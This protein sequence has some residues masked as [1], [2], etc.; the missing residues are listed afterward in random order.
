MTRRRRGAL[1][2]AG[3]AL[4]LG[5]PAAGQPP[6]DAPGPRPRE[7]REVGSH[8]GGAAGVGLSP[9]GKWVASG[10]GDQTIRVWA[11]ATGRE[12]RALPGASGFT[13]CVAFS[14][15]GKLLASAGYE[16]DRSRVAVYLYDAA[17]GAERGRL[18]GHPGGAR[19]LA[20][21]PDGKRLV[22]GGFD[23][24][25][26][27]WDLATNKELRC[28]KVRGC[29]FGLALS[30]DVRT[31]A[32]ADNGGT[33]L[34]ELDTGKELRKFGPPSAQALAVALSPD[35]RLLASGGRRSVTLYEVAT[36]KEVRTLEG[37]GE[38]LSSLFFSPDGRLLYSGS[39][40]HTV[41]V[42]E[43]FTGLEARK[44]EGHT[45]WVWNLALTSDGRSLASC[46]SDGRV[47]LWDVGGPPRPDRTVKLSPRELEGYWD[48]LA[49][50]AA[51]RA[52]Q[53]VHALAASSEQS[54]PFLKAR[55][56]AV[57]P[58]K[59]PSD[60]E[61]A[62]LV[63]ELDDNAFAVRQRAEAELAKAGRSAEAVLR[64]AAEKPASPEVRRRAERLL[65]AFAAGRPKPEEMR[66]V[67][68]VQALEYAGTAEAREALAAL[69]A[70]P[71][72][73]RLTREAKRAADRLAKKK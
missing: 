60:E 6:A 15:D 12:L 27:V 64:R 24:T 56:G 3:V 58:A 61:L 26:R 46:G 7:Y 22:S 38:Q 68:G 36:G 73:E 16:K 48:D 4:A 55:L 65:A 32:T 40:D 25:V 23:G 52:L 44:L 9:D 39:Y 71:P 37:L 33:T 42:W 2:A 28:L 34:W 59:G 11:A 49:G 54:V 47:L 19:R 35:G 67:R 41:R 50:E 5:L 18:E 8:K 72:A 13:C 29:V 51:G 62:R 20:F 70:G 21:T 31:V 63:R 45:A 57:R 17:T 30:A 53:A 1:L 14:P 66:A 69:A 43:V 10:G